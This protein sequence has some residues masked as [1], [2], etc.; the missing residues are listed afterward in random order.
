MAMTFLPLRCLGL[1]LCGVIA[2]I[3][4]GLSM[5]CATEDQREGRESL[6]VWRSA[7]QFPCRILARIAL[8]LYGFYWISTKG[9]P[10][11]SNDAKVI[12]SNHITAIDPLLIYYFYGCS[13]IA[14]VLMS[15]LCGNKCS[16]Q[17]EST[18]Y[19]GLYQMLFKL[20]CV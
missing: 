2:I 11:S 16:L 17:C 10:A 20:Y 15:S 19:L 4:S 5:L 8:F 3:F 18:L 13:F 9:K 1:L 6:P 12:V 14:R 7:L